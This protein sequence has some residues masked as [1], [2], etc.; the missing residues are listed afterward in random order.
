MARLRNWHIGKIESGD[1]KV[2]S[3]IDSQQS[4]VKTSPRM[5]S[6]LTVDCELSTNW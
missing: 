4:T 2:R 5:F 3:T 1:W 6:L